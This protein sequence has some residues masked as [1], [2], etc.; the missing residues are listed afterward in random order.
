MARYTEGN[1]LTPGN[2]M[3]EREKKVLTALEGSDVTPSDTENSEEGKTKKTHRERFIGLARLAGEGALLAASVVGLN[4]LDAYL[5]SRSSLETFRSSSGSIR[6]VCPTYPLSSDPTVRSFPEVLDQKLTALSVFDPQLREC[7]AQGLQVVVQSEMEWEGPSGE[8]CYLSQEGV[9]AIHGERFFQLI[10]RENLRNDE[11]TEDDRIEVT[12]IRTALAFSRA[13]SRQRIYRQLRS[14]SLPVQLLDSAEL[15]GCL[16]ARV[17]AHSAV[18]F[19]DASSGSQDYLRGALHD[20][21]SLGW[22]PPVYSDFSPKTRV[23]AFQRFFGVPSFKE[24]AFPDSETYER[25]ASTIRHEIENSEESVQQIQTALLDNTLARIARISEG[26]VDL[27]ADWCHWWNSYSSDEGYREYSAVTELAALTSCGPLEK[28]PEQAQAIQSIMNSS[29]E[30]YRSKRDSYFETK[31]G[32][33]APHPWKGANEFLLFAS[34]LEACSRLLPEGGESE[35]RKEMLNDCIRMADASIRALEHYGD[36]SYRV[37][38]TYYPVLCESRLLLQRIFGEEDP[39]VQRIATAEA[40]FSTLAE[41]YIPAPTDTRETIEVE[42]LPS[43][44]YLG[45]RARAWHNYLLNSYIQRIDYEPPSM[46]GGM[47]GFSVSAS[48]QLRSDWFTQ[49]TPSA[50]AAMIEGSIAE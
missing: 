44:S 3:Q 49:C 12:A 34:S 39:E 28:T 31:D 40:E 26:R 43:Y 35:L 50:Q 41:S 11:M 30:M 6:L 21:G 38:H 25:A 46:R 47:G 24:R 2:R 32:I 9:F 22:T 18:L 36:D 27:H 7:L 33:E 16:N 37:V 4:R 13:A 29:L 20:Q 8:L 48:E 42:T 14:E 17:A 5:S 15:Q 19:A 45:E 10:E 1:G 23:K